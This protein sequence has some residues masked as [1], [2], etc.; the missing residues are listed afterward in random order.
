MKNIVLIGGGSSIEN[1]LPSLWDK[2][3]QSEV[4]IWSINFTF[5]TMPFLPKVQVWVDIS[6]F[7]N[8]ME[9]LQNLQK[10]GVKCYAKKHMKYANIPEVITYETTRDPK[11]M[12]KKTFIGR[13]GLAG[14]FALHLAIKECP[15]MIA[16]LGYDFGSNTTKTH[17][18]QDTHKVQSSGVGRPELYRNGNSVKDEVK[19]FEVLKLDADSKNIKIFNVSPD[20]AINYFP[21][22]T[23]EQFFNL[24]EKNET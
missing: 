4:E 8:N 13:M 21:K 2:L 9:A 17:Y 20:S 15:D 23:Y 22:I 18:Y 10:Q 3:K 19:D 11:D 14:F 5:L 16:L 12:N 6:F 7:Q 24:I 1:Q